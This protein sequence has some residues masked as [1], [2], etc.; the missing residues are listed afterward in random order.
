MVVR[1][2]VRGKIM[3]KLVSLA[4]IMA[5]C[6]ATQAWAEV[7][8]TDD[9]FVVPC[10]P[11]E[12]ST[13]QMQFSTNTLP[14]K[15]GVPTDIYLYGGGTLEAITNYEIRANKQIVCWTSEYTV[16]PI[17]HCTVTMKAPG[18]YTFDAIPQQGNGLPPYPVTVSVSP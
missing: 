6:F 4:A 17:R 13:V 5:S 16:T 9:G 8:L 14:T 3:K 12:P 18:T 11:E 1:E 15:V 10:T 7:C 2:N